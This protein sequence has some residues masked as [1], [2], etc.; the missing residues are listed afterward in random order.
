MFGETLNVDDNNA[1]SGDL[2]CAGLA[3]SIDYR[4]VCSGIQ[5]RSCCSGIIKMVEHEPEQPHLLLRSTL[6]IS[7][8][9]FTV[10]E[11]FQINS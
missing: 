1:C 11:S 7:S 8:V 5:R 6:K 10:A 3:M 4:V 9:S 2:E